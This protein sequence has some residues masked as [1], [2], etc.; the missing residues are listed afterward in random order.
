[1]GDKEIFPFKDI[2]QDLWTGGNP[3]IDPLVPAVIKVWSQVVPDSLRP[4]VCLEGIRE[5][6]LHLLVSNPVV[7]QHLQFLKESIQKKMNEL[8]GGPV[9]KGIRVKSGAFPEVPS[10]ESEATGTHKPRTPGKW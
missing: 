2:V 3:L 9:V 8:L 6:T 10:A 4:A 5:G 1:M 7:G